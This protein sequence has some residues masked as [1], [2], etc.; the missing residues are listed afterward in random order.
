MFVVCPSCSGPFRIPAD[1]IAPLVQTACPHCRFRMILDFEA[2]NEPSLVEPGHLMAQ[3]FETA[4][5]YFSVYSHV[6]PQ[7]GV[8]PRRVEA[9]QP[10]PEPVAPTK[11]PPTTP[12]VAARPTQ[13]PATTPTGPQPTVSAA[14]SSPSLSQSASQSTPQGRGPNVGTKTVISYPKKPASMDAGKPDLT[15]A[16]SPPQQSTVR[17]GR[18]ADAQSEPPSVAAE[19]KAAVAEADRRPPPHTPPLTGA[20]SNA[21]TP[22]PVHV[23]AQDPAEQS[24]TNLNKAAPPPPNADIK[25]VDRPPEPV[26]KPTETKS[27]AMI[28][29]IIVAVIAVVVVVL[30][31]MNRS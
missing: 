16:T 20:L 14:S 7:A 13:T 1:Q 15:N 18:N 29:I 24:A 21:P 19:V 22:E 10:T 11:A 8:E 30:V 12:P 9:P 27:S 31:M 4:E 25:P 23:K 3:G 28:Y 5:A 17:L 6:G 26:V 2:A